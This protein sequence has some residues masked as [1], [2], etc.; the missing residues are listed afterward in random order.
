MSK[1]L[2]ENIETIENKI[3]TIRGKQVMVDR[4]LAYLY[5]VETR[6]LNQAVSR[7]MERFPSEFM[8]KLSKTE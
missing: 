6:V 8:F 5:E 3:M 7:N 4:D 1:T 2:M